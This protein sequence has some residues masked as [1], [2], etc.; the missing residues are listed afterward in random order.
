VSSCLDAFG[1]L[2]VVAV[3]AGIADDEHSSA[4]AATGL[5]GSHDK[6]VLGCVCVCVRVYRFEMEAIMFVLFEQL[7]GL[8]K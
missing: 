8:V 2:G 1:A 6:I 5:V 3:G 7:V 4:L